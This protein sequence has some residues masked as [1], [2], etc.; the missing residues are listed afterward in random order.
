MRRNW[1]TASSAACW[2]RCRAAPS[3][4]RAGPS[5]PVNPIR[6][7]NKFHFRK[8][9]Q[10]G[11]AV[12][13][14]NGESIN[15]ECIR[16]SAFKF[17]PQIP[18]APALTVPRIDHH[19]IGTVVRAGQ[20]PASRVAFRGIVGRGDGIASDSVPVSLRELELNPSRGCAPCQPFRGSRIIEIG[21]AHV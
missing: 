13:A 8:S 3:P 17:A 15:I 9:G 1:C 6:K 14:G 20:G 2:T 18:S 7:T 19:P 4:T 12:I 21:R 11:A 10:V 16:M 5:R